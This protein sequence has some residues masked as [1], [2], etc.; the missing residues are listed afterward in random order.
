MLFKKE[1]P[2]PEQAMQEQIK[3]T[4]AGEVEQNPFSEQAKLLIAMQDEGKLPEGFELES[5]CADPAFAALLQSFDAAAAVRIYAAEQKAA[6]AYEEAMA[7]MTEKQRMRSALPKTTK[8]NRAVSA[9]PD[10]MSLSA[11]EFRELENRIKAAAK[12]GKR[13]T[14]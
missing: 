13:I 11:S 5:A 6:H 10:Y 8:P 9:S 1:T 3:E 7:A 4:P 2:V 14:L 12:N